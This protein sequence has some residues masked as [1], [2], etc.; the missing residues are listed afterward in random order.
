MEAIRRL[1]N[2]RTGLAAMCTPPP[3]ALTSDYY[4]AALI[5]LVRAAMETPP[6]AGA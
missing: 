4:A 1:V 5:M 3:I 6:D 2:D